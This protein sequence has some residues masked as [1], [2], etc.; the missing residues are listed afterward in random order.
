MKSPLDYPLSPHTGGLFRTKIFLK[1]RGIQILAL[2]EFED[3][4]YDMLL[5]AEEEEMHIYSKTKA[6]S[7]ALLEA[8]N[9]QR[10]NIKICITR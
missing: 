6:Q 7:S 2:D 10:R 4:R 8:L 1:F 3:F 9:F 5:V